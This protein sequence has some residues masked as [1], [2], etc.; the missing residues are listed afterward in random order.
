VEPSTELFSVD[1]TNPENK[2]KCSAGYVIPNFHRR[3]EG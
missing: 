3:L 2:Q 1:Q